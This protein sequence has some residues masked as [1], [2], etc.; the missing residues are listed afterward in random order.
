MRIW[1]SWNSWAAL[2][3]GVENVRSV[4]K[5]VRRFLKTL[6]T[7]LSRNPD[8]TSV[9]IIPQRSQSRD[10]TGIGT[11]TFMPA[12]F[13]AAKRWRQPKGPSANRSV[14]KSSNEVDN[15]MQYYSVLRGEEMLTR[16]THGWTSMTLHEMQWARSERTNT[17]RFHSCELQEHQIHREKSLVVTRGWEE[18]TMRG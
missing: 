9:S 12:L 11:P 2:H 10:Q 3:G 16:A 1:R 14:D 5:T 15:S 17:V 13:T 4:W 8:S 7:E 18:G 6:S